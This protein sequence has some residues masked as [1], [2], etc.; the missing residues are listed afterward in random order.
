MAQ[1]VVCL[2][3]IAAGSTAFQ[4]SIAGLNHFGEPFDMFGPPQRIFCTQTD[5]Q[6]CCDCILGANCDEGP[7]RRNACM[8]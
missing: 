5:L 6:L 7:S 1:R 3:A 4:P 2:A 8:I